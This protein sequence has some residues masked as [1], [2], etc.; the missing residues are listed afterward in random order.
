MNKARKSARAAS[1]R[2][3]EAARAT[4]FSIRPARSEDA[5]ILV[6]LVR[7]LAVYEKLQERAR[8][9][10]DDFRRHLFGP[11]PAAE[12]VLAEVEGEAA[13]FALWFTVFST[14]R[15][16]PG[17]YLEDI[18]VRPV[19]RGCGIGKGL[20]A[21]VARRAVECG[22]AWLEWSVL[23]RNTP[24]IGFYR[25]L[26]ARPMDDW[27]VYRLDDEPLRRLAA[28]AVPR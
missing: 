18:F 28:L 9:T 17:L 15:G 7:E 25:S 23:D 12:A 14:F 19:H 11:H 22:S 1:L 8:A 26:G 6:N 16:Q 10:G 2:P 21:T 4:G 20:L 24:A 27:T 13:G 3:I 5:E